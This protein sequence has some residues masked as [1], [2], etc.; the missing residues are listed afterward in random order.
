MQNVTFLLSK[1]SRRCEANMEFVCE[2]ISHGKHLHQ[3]LASLLPTRKWIRMLTKECASTKR[4]RSRERAQ[5][6]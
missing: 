6:R 3:K 2:K 4:N 5:T 1:T